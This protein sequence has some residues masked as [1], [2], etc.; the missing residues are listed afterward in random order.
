MPFRK[1]DKVVVGRGVEAGSRSQ[2]ISSTL[3]TGLLLISLVFKVL[4]LPPSHLVTLVAP[5][6][7]G[8]DLFLVKVTLTLLQMG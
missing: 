4:R 1:R 8:R 7:K 6:E 5:V 2:W 3:R